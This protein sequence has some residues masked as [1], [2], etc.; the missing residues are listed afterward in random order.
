MFPEHVIYT[1]VV[2]E[3]KYLLSQTTPFLLGMK[4][5]KFLLRILLHILI[6]TSLL[7]SFWSGAGNFNVVNSPKAKQ[8][9]FFLH[10]CLS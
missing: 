1:E 4:F 2:K 5:N 10:I 7:V 6:F 9:L 3:S 8:S